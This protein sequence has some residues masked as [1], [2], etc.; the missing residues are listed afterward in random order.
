QR[1][2]MPILQTERSWTLPSVSITVPAGQSLFL[3]LS[4]VSEMFAMHG[5]RSPGGWLLEDT[6]V[7]LPV[8]E[9]VR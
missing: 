6:V 8:V 1:E 9:R 3:T 5:S 4:P 2:L 7:T